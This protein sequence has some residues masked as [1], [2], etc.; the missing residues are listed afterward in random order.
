[1][2]AYQSNIDKLLNFSGLRQLP[3]IMQTEVAECGLACLAMVGGYHGLQTD[4]ISLRQKFPI[5]SHG[6]NL[7]NLIDIS[8]GMN[9]TTRAL[10]CEIDSL[11]YI[12]LP[13]IIHWSMSHFVVLKEVKNNSMVIHDP[14]IGRRKISKAEFSKEYTGILLELIPADNFVK[15]VETRPLK[16]SHFWNVATGL[17]RSLIQILVISFLLQVF[18]LTAPIYLQIT[19]DDVLLRN[20]QSLLLVLAIGFFLLMLIQ[21]GTKVLREFII[22][23]VSNRLG[24]Q[25]SSNLFRHLIRLP[26]DYFQKRH[27]GD[28]V[29]RFGSLRKVREILTHGIVA[30]VI[31]G[32]MAFITVIAM[33]FYSKTLA[34]IVVGVVIIYALSRYF[35]YQPIRSLTEESIVAG[36]RENT[37]FMESVKAIQTIKIFQKENDRQN[38]WQNRLA[39]VM[40]KD[41]RIAKW[42]IGFDTTND[43]LFG[44]ENI[45][46]IYFAAMAI[47]NSEMSIGMLYAFMSYKGHFISSVVSL[48][49]KLVEIKMLDV[50]LNRI[51]DIAF[52]ETENIENF[53]ASENIGTQ[54][55][56]DE[57]GNKI[58]G[59]IEVKNLAFRYSE[60]QPYIFK[61]LSFCI[62][63]GEAVA[64]TGPSGSGKT[65]LLKCL[66]SLTAPTDGKIFIDDKPLTNQKG[67]RSQI[68]AVMQDDQLMSGNILDNITFFSQSANF[69][70]AM[71]CARFASI[72]DEIMA[73][74]MNYYTQVGDMGA[75]LSGGQ[76]QRIILARALYRKP[77]ILF[78]DEATSHL[79][80]NNEALVN[81]YI[82]ELNITRIIVAH[83]PETVRTADRQIQI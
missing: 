17:K 66:M 72:H 16:L 52:T 56:Q 63:P 59:K 15:N 74:S 31:D 73:M 60:D 33:F 1:M 37:H 51:A 62:F 22:L 8:A 53:T 25:M 64:I 81:S 4:I 11:K 18:A 77:S 10:T 36:A 40:N 47:M 3:L 55:H 43:L 5:S 50:H 41:I 58:L 61:D 71:E 49:N 65:T 54:S 46:V 7:K 76:K 79:D 34:L 57:L 26:I 80:I 70:F 23:Q 9:L 24:I 19:V 42:T 14:A 35:F 21:V 38:Q 44:L 67:Y 48:I 6:S 2:T 32:F 83:R 69:E 68:A 78:M 27:M 13:C 29:S 20:D 39:F 75:N 45:L 28:I 82:K 12:Q 30:A